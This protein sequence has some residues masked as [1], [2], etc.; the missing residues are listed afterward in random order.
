MNSD[1]GNRLNIIII[2][3]GYYSYCTVYGF[4]KL[5]YVGPFKYLIVYEK[6]TNNKYA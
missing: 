3:M 2:F 6:I 5:N 1:F 4:A